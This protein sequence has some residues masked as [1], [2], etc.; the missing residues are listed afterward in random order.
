MNRFAASRLMDHL[1]TL[2]VN[3]NS[4]SGNSFF[5]CDSHC[6][7]LHFEFLAAFLL[8]K[9]TRILNAA[10]VVRAR[11][12]LRRWPPPVWATH[13]RKAG[14]ITH[15]RRDPSLSY[16]SSHHGLFHWAVF[17][18]IIIDREK[19]LGNQS[20][21]HILKAP[22]RGRRELLRQPFWRE[23]DL[24]RDCFDFERRSAEKHAPAR[25]A[26]VASRVRLNL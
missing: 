1:F 16:V 17:R 12:A 6:A 7:G 4:I 18:P 23:H 26:G 2:F 5:I 11:R 25:A 21:I 22:R 3:R 9:F 24:S 19:W 20:P 8:K 14:W 13:F 10:G 15:S